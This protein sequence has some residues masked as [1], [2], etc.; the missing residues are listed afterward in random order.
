MGVMWTTWR[1]L[2]A[3]L[4]AMQLP[5]LTWVNASGIKYFMATCPKQNCDLVCGT[6]G[7]R[8]AKN[9]QSFPNTSALQVFESLG[10]K[11]KTD[12]YTDVYKF[13]DQPNY[14][15]ESPESSKD[16]IGRCLGFKS[17]PSTI[18]CHTASN[19]L[20]R[21]LCPCHDPSVSYQSTTTQPSRPSTTTLILPKPTPSKQPGTSGETKATDVLSP[22]QNEFQPR[23]QL[24]HSNEAERTAL[25][26]V[27]ILAAGL[28][29]CLLGIGLLFL[30]NRRQLREQTYSEKL[31]VEYHKNNNKAC[32]SA[33]M[34]DG[35]AWKLY[36]EV[37]SGYCD[38]RAA[39]VGLPKMGSREM[40]FEIP[41]EEPSN[42]EDMAG[43]QA[44]DN[45]LYARTSEET[46]NA[47]LA[48][49]NEP[50]YDRPV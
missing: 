8:C 21:R 28:V 16:W 50:V 2:L 18:D 25:I 44:S 14:M 11:C 46:N 12:N 48:D 24:G 4:I 33:D 45:V 35:L 5:V 31:H 3:T 10:I 7:L 42:Y 39:D 34:M 43:T 23:K 13:K 30:W 9:G 29:L 26:V 6:F 27:G 49:Q 19:S 17:I 37:E 1:K 47:L 22:A 41:T 38:M 36:T 32:S 40:E 15:A 20:V